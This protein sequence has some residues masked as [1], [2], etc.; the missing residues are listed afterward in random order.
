MDTPNVTEKIGLI[1]QEFHFI[2]CFLD[3]RRVRLWCAARAKAYDLAHGR[4]GVS[5]VHK[6]TGI[7]RPRIYKGLKEI[8][9]EDKLHKGRVRKSGGGRRKIA[10][11]QPGILEALENLVEPLTRGDPESPLRWTCKSTYQLKD[12]LIMQGYE[13]SQPQVGKLLGKLGYSLQS[14]RKT[15]EGGEHYDRDDQFRYISEKI[16][17]FQKLGLPAV[18]VDTKKKENIGNYE[19]KGKEYHRK[20]QPERVKV[21]DFIDKE[22]GKVAPYG[23]YDIGKNTGFVN[24]GI[25]SDT[26]EFAVNSIRNWWYEMGRSDYPD[27]AEILITADCGGSNSN[28]ARL[29]K[30]ELQ[31]LADELRMI[32]SVCHFPPGTSKWNKIEHRMFCHITKN[33]RGRPLISRETVV[34]LIGNTKT[35]TGL[36]IRAKL[37]ENIYEKGRK[38]TD[39]ELESVNIERSDFHGE[40]NYRIK[41]SNIQ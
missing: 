29:W 30:T 3:E 8:E 21:Y 23:I 38:I 36:K 33:W 2:S 17:Y 22:L 6:A 5:A 35:K 31:K 25:S 28:R 7:S 9:S 39:R 40:W 34:N 1:Q 20:G 15:E 18:S 27:A 14:N 16:M 24:V 41:M 26:A 12:E 19:N 11:K 10:E 13:I 32:V 4:G 37:D